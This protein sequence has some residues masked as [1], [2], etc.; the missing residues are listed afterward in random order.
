MEVSAHHA[1]LFH[2]AGS[3]W[4]QDTESRNGTFVN[5][6]RIHTDTQ[7][8]DTDQ[9]QFGEGGPKLEFRCVA[10]GT[11]DGIISPA[12]AAP[13][14]EPR[15]I[16]A[17][18]EG[19][20]PRESTTQR[21]RVEVGRQTRRLRIVVG[22]LFAAFVIVVGSV[23]VFSRA[24][25]QRRAAEVAALQARTDSIMRASEEAVAALRGQV[26]GLASRLRASQ[27]EVTRLQRDLTA[28]QQAGSSD[29]VAALSREL[30]DASRHL[31]YQQI[32]AHVDFVGIADRN[33]QA[34]ALIWVRFG[35]R[36]IFTGTAFAVRSDGVLLTNR[37]VVAG[38]DG[39]RQP[40][41]IAV[42]FADSE[43]TWR[44]R[45]LGVSP[46][47]DL[48]AVKVDI[49]GG[50]PTVQALNLRP[51]TLRQGDPVALIGFPLGTELPMAGA[52]ARSS[53]FAGSVSKVL[54]DVVQIDG[55]GTAGASGSPIFDRNGDVIAVLFG[56][57]PGA[58]G[59]IVYGVPSS[60]AAR[61]LETLE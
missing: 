41:E 45:V 6:H 59:R 19:E 23:V 11:A 54:N 15:L 55:Y 9:I 27:T 49:R 46:D 50:V 20:Q 47:A 61:L 28:A 2:K 36:E 10:D 30:A 37:H 4:V 8:D 35:P 5:G 3:W 40:I 33:Q 24:Q 56:G 52:V 25:T 12:A 39:T 53:L 13:S 42:R 16:R 58:G 44:G 31:Q 32:A 18:S 60:Y 29:R 1:V 17:T 14:A 22:A 51:D 21:I 57:Q 34:V 7:L 43:Q 48:A 38:E 26:Q